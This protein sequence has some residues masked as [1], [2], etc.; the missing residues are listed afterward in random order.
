MANLN[1]VK[2]QKAFLVS[3]LRGTNRTITEAQAA[4]NYG[5]M[6][7]RARMSELRAAG[8]KVSTVETKS[9]KVA[10]KVAARD[11]NGSRAAVA[12]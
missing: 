6:N 2:N 1:K 7:L 12:V 5:I 9:G 11:V 3:Y 4:A 8:L 10:Y